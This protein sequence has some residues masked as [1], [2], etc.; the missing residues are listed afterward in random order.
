M[1]SS[2]FEFEKIEPT[3]AKIIATSG[4]GA[5]LITENSVGKGHVILTTPRWMMTRDGWAVPLQPHL[6]LHVASGL[7]PVSVRG[8]VEYTINK[9][10]KG[11]LVGLLNNRG[12]HKMAHAQAVVRHEED[13]DVEVFYRGNPYSRLT[14]Q[15][16]DVKLVEIQE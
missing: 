12:V 15:A 3:T 6:A 11:W 1:A 5:P 7:L 16:G 9:T 10:A 13:A 8:N 2:E 14:V 4:S